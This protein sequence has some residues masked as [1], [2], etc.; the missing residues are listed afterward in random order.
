MKETS[1]IAA[2]VKY[3]REKQKLTQEQL[4]DMTGVGLHFLRDLEQGRS[5]LRL[6]KVNLVISNL[7]KRNLK[8]SF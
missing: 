4:A 7:A 6:D 3:Q 5:K 8:S 2:F 1:N